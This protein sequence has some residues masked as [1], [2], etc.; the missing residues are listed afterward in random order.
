MVQQLMQT[1][2]GRETNDIHSRL[3]IVAAYSAVRYLRLIAAWVLITVPCLA[4]SVLTHEVDPISWTKFRP[5]LD[6]AAG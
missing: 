4:Y 1:A 5:F 2:L 6:G 3:L